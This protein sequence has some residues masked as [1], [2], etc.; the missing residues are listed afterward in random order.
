MSR[1]LVVVVLLLLCACGDQR[2][3]H[4][5][6]A[7]T[8]QLVVTWHA[9]ESEAW[10]A[11]RGELTDGVS[12]V[13]AVGRS[14]GYNWRDAWCI[15]RRDDFAKLRLGQLISF[16]HESG[17]LVCHT[18]VGN[19]SGGWITAGTANPRVDRGRVTADNYQSRVIAVHTWPQ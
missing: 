4:H 18:L 1:L 6:D 13:H 5:P 17:I 16:R 19:D 3:F 2:A 14:N 15:A 12:I 10:L 11:A 8:M 7:E 9:T